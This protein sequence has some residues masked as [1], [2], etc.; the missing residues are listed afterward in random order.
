MILEE[1]DAHVKAG[2]PPTWWH[3]G[4]EDAEML[5]DM[6]IRS[7][8]ERGTITEIPDSV[9]RLGTTIIIYHKGT[10]G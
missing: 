4:K 5:V 3:L 1:Y 7:D 6:M 10:V 2:R 9:G 8:F